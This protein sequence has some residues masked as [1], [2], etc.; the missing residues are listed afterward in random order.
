METEID[1]DMEYCY[2]TD[3]GHIRDLD[4]LGHIHIIMYV[5]IYI[6]IHDIHGIL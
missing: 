6:Y 5:C 2:I 3:S 4:D 1:N